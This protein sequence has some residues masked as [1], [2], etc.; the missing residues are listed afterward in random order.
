MILL[1]VKKT[2]CLG[3]V[4]DMILTEAKKERDLFLQPI[5]DVE[6][7]IEHAERTLNELIHRW[8]RDVKPSLKPSA[9]ESYEWGLKRII[10]RFGPMPVSEI[11]KA[12]VQAFLTGTSRELAPE[13]V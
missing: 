11:E 3:R 5:N 12:D 6:P 4:E 10:P 1:E 7:G 8:R 13:S 2:K 9:Q